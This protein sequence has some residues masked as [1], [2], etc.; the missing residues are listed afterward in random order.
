MIRRK[1]PTI[2]PIG[3]DAKTAIKAEPKRTVGKSGLRCIP[4][5]ANTSVA[6]P[7]TAKIAA[8]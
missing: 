6:E 7:T 8:T 4:V 3:I 5:A 1:L 2:T